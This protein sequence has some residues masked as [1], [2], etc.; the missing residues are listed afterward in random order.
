MHSGH[1]LFSWDSMQQHRHNP[2]NT[3]R[4]P[5][6]RILRCLD[7]TY[8]CMDGTGLP[9][10][11][12]ST[13]LPGFAFSDHAPVWAD[14]TMGPRVQRPSCHQMNPSHFS[15]PAFKDRIINMWERGVAR[16]L[17]CGWAPHH[18]L[19]ICIGEARKIDRC[20]GKRMAQERRL[21]LDALQ[22]LVAEAQITLEGDPDNALHQTALQ[23]AREN[24]NSFN[25]AQARWVDSIIQARWIKAGDKSSQIFYHQFKDL[26]SAKDIKELYDENGMLETTWDGMARTTTAFFLNILG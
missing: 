8:F 4:P 6:G 13:I 20:W 18:T 14:L 3:T 24:L 17:V 1:L 22:N 19:Q 12:S 7:R 5:G 10:E 2:V 15:N 25:S 26:A 23:V 16:G 11:F 21:R 9:W